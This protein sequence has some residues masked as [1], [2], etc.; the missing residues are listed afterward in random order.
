MKSIA[1]VIFT[2]TCL[3]LPVAIFFGTV[4]IGLG[5]LSVLLPAIIISSLILVGLTNSVLGIIEGGYKRVLWSSSITM[6]IM[7]LSIWFVFYTLAS[8]RWQ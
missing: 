2:L 8:I 3:V 5:G 1:L 6:A 7:L 4:I